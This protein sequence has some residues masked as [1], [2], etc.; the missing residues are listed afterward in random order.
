MDHQWFAED[1]EFAGELDSEPTAELFLHSDTAHLFADSLLAS[2]DPKQAIFSSSADWH[3]LLSSPKLI[4]DSFPKVSTV[5]SPSSVRGRPDEMGRSLEITDKITPRG[6]GTTSARARRATVDDVQA[7]VELRV[8]MFRAMGVETDTPGWQDAAH[9]WFA[10]RIDAPDYGFFVVRTDEEVVAAAVGAI[11][12]AAP[13][14]A[15]PEGRD[16][17]ISNVSTFPE[18]R[19]LGYGR[20]A[21]NAVMDWARGTGIERAELMATETGRRMYERAGFEETRWPAMRAIL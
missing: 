9:T 4:T 15:C 3:F 8:E 11:R 7:L 17:L 20:E 1:L 16:L 13:S 14:P 12:D 6:D 2:Y 5:W 18:H 21:F 10:E 19:G